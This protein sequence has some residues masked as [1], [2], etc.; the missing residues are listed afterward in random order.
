MSV[1]IITGE[2][3]EVTATQLCIACGKS[4]VRKDPRKKIRLC[5]IVLKYEGVIYKAWF[6]GK[7]YRISLLNIVKKTLKYNQV[8]PTKKLTGNMIVNNS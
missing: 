6:C 1:Q 7:C 5:Y 4:G 2:F 3:R 8:V